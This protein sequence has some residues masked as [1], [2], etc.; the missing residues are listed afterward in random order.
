MQ[1]FILDI[2]G[3]TLVLIA[4]AMGSLGA[5]GLALCDKVDTDSKWGARLFWFSLILNVGCLVP[6][7]AA[8]W[9]TTVN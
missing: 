3:T 5:A 6:G 1:E 9:T 8:A 4:I 7:F 2:G